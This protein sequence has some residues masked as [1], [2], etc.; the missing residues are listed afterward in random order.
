MMVASISLPS[1]F[2]LFRSWHEIAFIAG[3]L[4]VYGIFMTGKE[5]WRK[6]RTKSWPTTTG[7]INDVK[8]EKVWGGVNGVDYW[9][10][11]FSYA[12]QVQQPHTGKYSFNCTSETMGQGAVAGMQDKTVSVHYKPSNEAETVIWEDEIWDIWWD[13]YWAMTHEDP[14]PGADQPTP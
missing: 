12:Y 9:K 7:T 6:H 10:V 4:A 8:V 1:I 3:A 2:L 5:K 11:T 14:A 13:T